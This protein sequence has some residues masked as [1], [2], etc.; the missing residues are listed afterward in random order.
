MSRDQRP[1]RT[2]M[3]APDATSAP[4]QR[5]ALDAAAATGDPGAPA[6]VAPA[7]SRTPM[8]AGLFLFACVAGAAG[9]ALAPWLL[10]GR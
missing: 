10:A 8:L 4:P 3:I 7:K 9:V 5:R 1:A 2:V 6:V